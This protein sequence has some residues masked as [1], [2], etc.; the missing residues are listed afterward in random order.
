MPKAGPRKENIEEL[1]GPFTKR[2]KEGIRL[3]HSMDR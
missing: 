1:D 2:K 3:M